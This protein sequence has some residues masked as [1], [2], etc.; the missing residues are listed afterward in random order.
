MKAFKEKNLRTGFDRA[1]VIRRC[2]SN[3]KIIMIISQKASIVLYNI[4]KKDIRNALILKSD[5][6]LDQF[7]EIV[8]T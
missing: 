8:N 4:Y 7:R 6:N 5:Y 2:F 3:C 1:K